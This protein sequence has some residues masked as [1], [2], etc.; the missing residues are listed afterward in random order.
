MAMLNYSI[1]KVQLRPTEKV[2]SLIAI[3]EGVFKGDFQKFLFFQRFAQKSRPLFSDLL[4][5][6]LSL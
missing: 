3:F 4:P 1:F 2:L 6:Y 5:H